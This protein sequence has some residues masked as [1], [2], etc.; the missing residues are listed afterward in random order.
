M[1]QQNKT[2]MAKEKTEVAILQPQL[3]EVVNKSGLE[4]TTAEKIAA[5]YV[6]YLAQITEL[7]EQL[8]PLNKELPEDAVKAKRIRLDLGKL[9][10]PMS[11]TK[12]EDKAAILVQGRY[13]DAL[14]NACE[15]AKLLTQKDAE[16]IEK[17]QENLE[18]QRLELVYNE[19]VLLL[20]PYGEINQFVDLKA[21]DE[22]TF[23]TYLANAKTVFDAKKEQE[24]LAEIARV[25]AEQ[26]ADQERIEREAAEK[27][28]REKIEKENAELKAA[29]IEREKQIAEQNRLAKIEQDKKDAELKIEAD[30]QAKIQADL[31][32]ENDRI[33]AELKAKKEA[34]EILHQQEKERIEAEEK[35]RVAKAKALANA[36]DKE[37]LR[38]FFD[39]YVAL[40]DT[41]PDLTSTEGKLISGR[42]TEALLMVK[43]LIVTD[44]K[45]LV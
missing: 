14:Y 5:K 4:Q 22:L 10:K 35:E 23:G 36:G 15:G 25:E 38:T 31:K 43:K 42:V 34:E 44:G 39:K 28:E 2:V 6:P 12:A 27:L 37:K 13:I 40:I 24:R 16:E 3:L 9:S 41:F 45:T 29:Q 26:K 20:E 7:G 21:M 11:D 1:K 32:A 33:A 8:K 17:H 30:K 19:R 18:K